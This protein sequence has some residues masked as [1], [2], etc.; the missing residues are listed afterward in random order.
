[1]LG[2]AEAAAHRFPDRVQLQLALARALEGVGQGDE[3]ETC[4]RSAVATWPGDEAV[5]AALAAKLGR[6]GRFEEALDCAGP[7]Q[8]R[9]WAAKLN[10]KLL[11]RQGRYRE[12]E[13]FTAAVA[14]VD[15]ADANLVGLRAARL[16]DDPE[17]L[18]A[19][20]EAALAHRP[21]VCEALYWK[22]IALALLGRSSEASAVMA[23][24]SY[25]Q[26]SRLPVPDGFDG[27]APFHAALRDEIR[28]NPTIHAD[29]VGHASSHGRRT[30]TFPMP[31]DGAASALLVAIREAISAYADGLRGDHE[32]VAARPESATINAWALTFGGAGHQ[33]VHHHPE[34]WL[35]GVYYVAAE[36]GG[37]AGAIRIGTLPASLGIEPPWP[38][39]E[40]QPV[41]GTLI[42]FPSFVPHETVPPGEGKERISIA[43]DVAA[44]D[45]A[46]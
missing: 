1:M 10:L 6:D 41:P 17:G 11:M 21:G 4:L 7:W 38:V 40:L 9:P 2:L 30:R 36:A 42:L 28:T 3:A 46:G 8:D 22:A 35:T 18:L 33:L 19:M 39:L 15:P 16:R 45:Q 29:P 44:A 20:C 32:F 12:A 14:A 34:A 13:G 31:G 23:I 37:V 26:V 24:E 25:V 43:F 27:N 5:A